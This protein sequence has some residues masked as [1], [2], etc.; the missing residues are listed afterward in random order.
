[1]TA[2][3]TRTDLAEL[4]SWR[5]TRPYTVDEVNPGPAREA[6]AT[7]RRGMDIVRMTVVCTDGT[8]S[9]AVT[10]TTEKPG[11]PAAKV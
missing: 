5:P 1:V 11:A 4:L 10:R 7:F 6:A 2:V 9:Q 8:P 3:C